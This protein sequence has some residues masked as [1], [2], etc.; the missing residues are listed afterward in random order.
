MSAFTLG[1]HQA[2][3]TVIGTVARGD[4]C[5]VGAVDVEG[6]GVGVEV[7]DEG[8]GGKESNQ[9]LK[10]VKIS[11]ICRNSIGMDGLDEMGWPSISIGDT[12]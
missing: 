12:P 5:C 10:S 1:E 7:G 9:G 8:E 3:G 6:M 2:R 11:S 4:G